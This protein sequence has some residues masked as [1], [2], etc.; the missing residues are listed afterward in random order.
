MAE[1]TYMNIDEYAAHMG[2]NPRTVRRWLAADAIPG[3]VREAH[4][5]TWRWWIPADAQPVLA[6]PKP[7]A[8]T[9]GEVRVMDAAPVVTNAPQTPPGGRWWYS[10]DDLAALWAPNVS[11]YAILAM[12][13]AG[14]LRALRRGH[15]GAWLV[16]ASELREIAGL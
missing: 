11:R 7:P 2:A 13:D 16:P 9:T 4:G 3:A 5:R 1:Q 6:A 12:I 10:V 14:E 8:G 15:N